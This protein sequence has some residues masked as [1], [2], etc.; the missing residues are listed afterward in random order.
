MTI[1]AADSVSMPTRQY[2]IENV[3]LSE[4]YEVL[5]W[6]YSMAGDGLPA[7]AKWIPESKLKVNI[8]PCSPLPLLASIVAL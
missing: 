6:A 8:L 4:E 7:S 5:V 2:L 1:S 3:D